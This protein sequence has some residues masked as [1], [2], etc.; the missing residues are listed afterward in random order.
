MKR[1]LLSATLGVAFIFAIPEIANA[2]SAVAVAVDAFRGTDAGRRFVQDVL[3]LSEASSAEE[4]IARIGEVA[5]E[6]R[7]Q[8]LSSITGAGFVKVPNDSSAS[9]LRAQ[10]ATLAEQIYDPS[11]G[12]LKISELVSK[13]STRAQAERTVGVKSEL[14][15][16][17]DCPLSFIN[18]RIY[19]YRLMYE[20]R[21]KYDLANV[22]S[23]LHKDHTACVE[24]AI[25]SGAGNSWS[26]VLEIVLLVA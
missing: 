14:L 2:Q 8:I 7:A 25:A 22:R 15:I 11:S 19:H 21:Y 17:N 12:A 3:N 6:N 9:T 18:F 26:V 16:R 13:Y 24:N 4:I 1:C 10:N 20:V 5:P 23:P